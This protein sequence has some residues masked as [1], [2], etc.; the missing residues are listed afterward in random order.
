MVRRPAYQPG[1]VI[2]E[3]ERLHLTEEPGDL[4][5]T[6]HE[7][8]ED[9]SAGAVVSN[10][11]GLITMSVS[12]TNPDDQPATESP[13]TFTIANGRSASA[14]QSV[15]WLDEDLLIENDSFSASM[16][17]IGQTE[18]ASCGEGV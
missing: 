2:E 7:V 15:D 11:G 17:T 4:T 13:L 10:D 3:I 5:A 6:L 16:D 12:V 9:G 14:P 1:E 18:R 8:N